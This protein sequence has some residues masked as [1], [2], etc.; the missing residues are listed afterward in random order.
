MRENT[1]NQ[2]SDEDSP[3]QLGNHRD[4]GYLNNAKSEPIHI[5]SKLMIERLSY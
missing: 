3:R 2:N 4:K 1:C 5:R